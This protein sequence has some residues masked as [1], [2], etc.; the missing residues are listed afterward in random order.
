MNVLFLSP[1]F[2]P[3][4]QLFCTALAAR[5]IT[6]LGIGDEP[7]DRLAPELAGALAEYVYLPQMHAYEVLRAAV[8]GL[9]AR[10]GAIDRLDSNG[11]HWLETEGRLR[12]DFAVWGPGLAEIRSLR[13]KLAMGERFAAAGIAT[14][15]S[16]GCDSPAL[17]RRFAE[18]HGFPLVVKPDAGSGAVDTF[19]VED[20]VGLADVLATPRPGH[21]VQPFVVGDI[22]TFDGLVDRDGTIVFC[23]S[24]AYDDG[25][26]QVRRGGLDGYYYSLREIPAALA[27][28]GRRAVAAFG[29][30][31]RFFHVEFFV[32]PDASIVALEMNVRPPGGFTTDMMCQ[33]CEIDVYALWAAVIAGERLGDFRYERRYHTAHV[34]RRHDRRYREPHGGLVAALGATLTAI[35]TVPAAFAA[36]MGDVAYLLRHRELAPLLAAVERVR[37]RG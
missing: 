18:T 3:N 17:V 33:A 34:G 26:M 14:P 11:E 19:M 1:G 37:A 15:A 20:P 27:A 5:G 23:T 4:A 21:I 6:V 9:V 16:T 22:V 30:R 2:P 10:H 29:L 36:T 28:S 7:A 31:E 8:R 35:H 32:R 12:D 25:I 24:H 13:S